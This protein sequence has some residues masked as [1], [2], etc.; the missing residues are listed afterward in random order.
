MSEHMDATQ[1]LAFVP[2]L[3]YGMGL[4]MLMSDW[5]RLFDI[6]QIYLPYTLLSL[7]ITEVAIYNVFIYIQ[8]IEEFKEQ[9]YLS[10]LSYLVSPFL[11]YLTTQVFTPDPGVNTKE[12]F[13]KRM[14]LFCSLLALLVGSHFIYELVESTNAVILRL[15]FIVLIIFIGFSRKPQ[16]T[17]LL[18]AFWAVSLFIRGAIILK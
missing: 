9:N 16:F 15:V 7:M 2:L 13:I 1:Y 6:K 17:Y 10:Y 11:F 4:T 18:L 12:Y 3:I 14:P 5:K 8:V